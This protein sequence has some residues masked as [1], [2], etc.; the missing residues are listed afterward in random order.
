MDETLRKILAE[1]Y[2]KDLE[3]SKLRSAVETLTAKL[4][5]LE[6]ENDGLKARS[7]MIERPGGENGTTELR[8]AQEHVQIGVRGPGKEDRE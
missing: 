5:E 4:V 8:R 6:E 2:A 1:L 3:V 7:F